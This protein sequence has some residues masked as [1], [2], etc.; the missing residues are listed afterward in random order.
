MISLYLNRAQVL[1]PASS[2]LEL[3][4]IA[5]E[6][7][8]NAKLRRNEL[9]ILNVE[10]THVLLVHIDD[11][12]I[13]NAFILHKLHRKLLTLKLYIINAKVKLSLYRP[14]RPLVLRELKLPHFQAFG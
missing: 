12:N 1:S 4:C 2:S 3:V 5:V 14:W 13:T 10:Y 7:I 11:T 9:K 8:R 6:L